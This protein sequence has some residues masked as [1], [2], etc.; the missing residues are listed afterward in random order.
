MSRSVEAAKGLHVKQK[1]QSSDVVLVNRSIGLAQLKDE[2]VFGL[3]PV[4]AILAIASHMSGSVALPASGTVQ[5][6]WMR[7]DGAAV[8]GGNTL[9]GTT[10]NLTGGRFIYGTSGAGA[11]VNPVSGATGGNANNQVTLTTTELPSHSHPNNTLAAAAA[12]AT[13]DH[14][15]VSASG[16][17]GAANAPHTHPASLSGSVAFDSAPHAHPLPNLA[18]FGNGPSIASVGN[19][20]TIV[21]AAIQGGTGASNVTLAANAPH[22]HALG[23]PAAAVGVTTVDAPHAHPSVSVSGSAASVNAPHSHTISGAIGSTGTGSAFSILPL[24]VAA[25]YMIR[26]K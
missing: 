26:V 19:G 24:Y 9:S 3:V 11:G 18:A 2:V 17:A 20:G 21:G 6:G 13:H 10:P 22:N 12:N 23:T 14:P 4:G 8:P 1:E 5:G 15:S 7:S 16:S 25:V